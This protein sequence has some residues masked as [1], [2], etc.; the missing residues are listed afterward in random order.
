MRTE[1]VEGGAVRV[2][3]LESISLVLM[4]RVPGDCRHGGTFLLLLIRNYA[5]LYKKRLLFVIE[6]SRITPNP[7]VINI[8]DTSLRGLRHLRGLDSC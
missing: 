1:R 4:G 7:H 8:Y 5:G 2:T 3:L 6:I